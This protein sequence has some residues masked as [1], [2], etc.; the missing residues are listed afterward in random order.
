M[1]GWS[2]NDSADVGPMQT[3][4]LQMLD[5]CKRQ[6]CRC[7]A[8]ANNDSADVGLNANDDFADVGLVQ[9]TILQMLGRCKQRFCSCWAND[10]VLNVFAN[11]KQTE[12]NHHFWDR[13]LRT[14]FMRIMGICRGSR[15][16]ETTE[17]C[18]DRISAHYSLNKAA[19]AV[20]VPVWSTLLAY[21][22]TNSLASTPTI[23]LTKKPRHQEFCDFG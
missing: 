20:P 23:I 2:N 6:L 10:I 4:I 18:S 1:L 19:M 12:G 7:W 21:I 22:P 13:T 8:H 17:I 5:W 9:T 14:G 3:T 11:A 16:L 15:L